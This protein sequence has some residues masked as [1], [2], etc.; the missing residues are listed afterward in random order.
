MIP[1]LN[2]WDVIKSSVDT[3]KLERIAIDYPIRFDDIL[4]LYAIT[5]DLDATRA[6]AQL[7]QRGW[8]MAAIKR[9]LFDEKSHA[10]DYDSGMEAQWREAQG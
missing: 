2:T 4:I 9:K 5:G 3:A 8:N 1:N 10:M 7:T 6:A